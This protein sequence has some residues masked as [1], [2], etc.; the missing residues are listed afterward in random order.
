M[1]APSDRQPSRTNLAASPRF[2]L[3]CVYDDPSNPATLT[4]FSPESENLTTEWVTV[5]R[6]SAVPLDRML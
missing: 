6:A 1:T 4:I 5:D 2:D 3:E